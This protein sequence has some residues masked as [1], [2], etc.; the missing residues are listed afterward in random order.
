MEMRPILTYGLTV[1]RNWSHVA[2]VGLWIIVLFGAV[3]T[4]IVV[5]RR[6]PVWIQ[7]YE[8]NQI[9]ALLQSLSSV[10]KVNLTT[11]LDSSGICQVYTAEVWLDG[12]TRRTLFLLNPTLDELRRGTHIRVASFDDYDL[13]AINPEGRMIT[14]VDMGSQGAFADLLPFEVHGVR[15]LIDRRDDVVVFL[16]SLPTRS[17][18]RSHIGGQY[19]LQVSRIQGG[20]IPEQ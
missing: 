17:K 12:N 1:R 19:E 3:V 20:E 14:F 2:V 6:A 10:R 16:G 9:R 11:G 5:V 7:D 8:V 18:F 15:D 13:D 4:I